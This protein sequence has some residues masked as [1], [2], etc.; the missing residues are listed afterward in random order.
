M[1]Q[2]PPKKLTTP[3]LLLDPKVLQRKTPVALSLEQ[4]VQAVKAIVPSVRALE[5]VSRLTLQRPLQGDKDFALHKPQGVW[6]SENLAAL[7]KE[8]TLL[9]RARSATPG[10]YLIDL[11][12]DTDWPGVAFTMTVEGRVSTTTIGHGDSHALFTISVDRPGPLN[13]TIKGA[14]RGE[15]DDDVYYFYGVELSKIR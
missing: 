14:V 10:Y 5:L 1:Q 4:R 7:T 8:S 9:L 6:F 3:P 15:N 13:I 11:T 12:T 2:P